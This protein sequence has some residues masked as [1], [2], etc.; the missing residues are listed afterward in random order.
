MTTISPHGRFTTVILTVTLTGFLAIAA[1]PW[2]LPSPAWAQAA[3]PAAVPAAAQA[4]PEAAP[5]PPDVPSLFEHWKIRF[6]LGARNFDLSG[7]RP[8]RFFESRDVIK[9]VYVRALNLRYESSDSP[10]LFFLKGSD[11]R[12]LDE[13][14]KADL[15]RVGKFRTT[16]LWDR[17]PH[18]YSDGTSLFQT[19]SRGNLVVSPSI[20]AAFQAVIE[21]TGLG[22]PPQ[23]INT[24]AISAFARR[25]LGAAPVIDLR[26][27]RDQATLRHSMQFGALEVHAQYRSIR[28]QGTRP[29]GIGTFARQ[30]IG[31]NIGDAVWESLAVELPEPVDYRT[32]AFNVGARA[33]GAKW[34]LGVD[35]RFTMFQ[36]RIAGLTYENPF[37]VTDAVGADAEGH[38]SP[39]RA[40]GRNRFVRQQV[41]LPPNTNFQSLTVSGGFDLPGSTQVRG[42][43]SWGQS[44]Q[45]DPFLPFT[46]NTALIGNLADGLAPNLPSGENVLNLAYLPQRSLNGKVR[47]LNYDGTLV[48]KPWN[49]MNFRLQ[50]RAEDVKNKSP[51]IVF[52]GQSR[53]GESHWV[54]SSDYYGLPIENFPVSYVRKD[55]IASWRWDLAKRVTWEAEY[56][57]ETWD[58][59][60]RDV[61]HSDEYSLK[62]RLEFQLA[63]RSKFTMDY[64]YANRIPETYITTPLTFNPVATSPIP[65]GFTAPTPQLPYPAWEVVRNA[66]NLYPQ[67]QRGVP[68]EFNQL[69]RFDV[70]NRRHHDA[71]AALDI[72]L[73]DKVT[74]SAS[75][76][77][78]RNNYSRGF[79]GLQFDE[80]ASADGEVTVTAGERT[81]LT[82][83]YSRQLNRYES[84]G[85]GSL[86]NSSVV[87]G[88]PCCAQYPIANT[89]VRASRST[90]N[91][92][93][94]GVNWASNGETTAIVLS[95]GFSFANDRIGGFN[96]FTVLLNSPLTATAYNYP[97]TKNGSQQ[98]YFTW[99]R[100]LRP[101][102]DLGL[103]YRFEAF[104]LDDF[105]LNPLS[106]YPEGRVTSG[107]IP[108]NLPRQLLLNARFTSY[109]AHQESFFLKYTF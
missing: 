11:I 96:P 21:P 88:N 52:P 90:L 36:S 76:Q 3:A 49:K 92:V 106:P 45:N 71:T 41:A 54:T 85:N 60:F 81:F 75:S 39:G 57:F 55:L 99:T 5:E 91:F 97:D 80:N 38:F 84:K 6:D 89:W 95:Y 32:H 46:L 65:A 1:L 40:S 68:L 28:Q 107:G 34:R 77:Y 7:D 22:L 9:G 18:Y 83:N 74:F 63:K 105:Y 67:F 44:T 59:T 50:Y 37:R 4:K 24:A 35:Y 87:N 43:L 69:R 12:E 14:V 33:S 48:S 27:K 42:L 16:F 78:Q 61:P 2:A 93:Q 58:R 8:G 19:A 10:Y 102:L 47:T 25:E 13:T 104:R 100:K 31:A 26:V 64:K 79:Y 86:I 73:G 51:R 17:L 53:F 29:K 70:T 30:N 23:S 20:R 66:N 15:W 82:F 108:V 56:Q 72:G 94:T 109:H 101:G 103:E 98:I 62:G